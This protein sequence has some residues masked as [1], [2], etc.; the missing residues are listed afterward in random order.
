MR[1]FMTVLLFF[2]LSLPLFADDALQLGAGALES[3]RAGRLED[4]QE[5]FLAA[6]LATARKTAEESRAN[7]LAITSVELFSMGETSEILLPDNPL[8][9]APGEFLLR[10]KLSGLDREEKQGRFRHGLRHVVIIKNP[11]GKTV[12]NETPVDLIDDFKAYTTRLHVTDRIPLPENWKAGNYSITLTVEDLLC[13]D[14]TAARA[15]QTLKFVLQ[16]Q[17]PAK[18]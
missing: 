16:P 4:A 6:A 10:L 15:E 8:I 1:L 14:A 18:E 17:I 13:P 2:S 5:G 9:A 7:P 11:D 12:L 3:Y